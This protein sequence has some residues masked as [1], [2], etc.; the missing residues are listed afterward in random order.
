MGGEN[1]QNH[2]H[3]RIEIPNVKH[4]RRAAV[5]HRARS[6]TRSISIQNEMGLR[7]EPNLDFNKSN[8]PRFCKKTDGIRVEKTMDVQYIGKSHRHHDGTFLRGLM[9]IGQ[10]SNPVV[11]LATAAA[12]RTFLVA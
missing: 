12:N 4:L 3:G 8:G 5:W 11:E 1:G 7:V 2:G 6:A 10:T 9:H